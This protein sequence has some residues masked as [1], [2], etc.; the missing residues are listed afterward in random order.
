MAALMTSQPITFLF[1]EV[2]SCFMLKNN[3]IANFIGRIIPGILSIILVPVL[4]RHLGVEAYGLVGLFVSLQAMISFLDMGLSTTTNREVAIGLNTADKSQRT[5]N[6]VL[7]FEALYIAISLFIALGIY[8]ISNW[9]AS[10]WIKT[11]EL[12][13][14]TVRFAVIVFGV[15]LAIRWPLALYNGILQGSENQVLYNILSVVLAVMR[16]GG[17]IVIVVFVSSTILAYLLWLLVF[18]IV[19]IAVF[20]VAAWRVMRG[21]MSQKPR[22]DFSLFRQVWKFSVS[23][24]LNS[25]LAAL[26]KQLDRFLISNLLLLK[27]VG[28]YTT[29]HI[30][31]TAVSMLAIPFASAA[32]PRF[33]ALL[34]MNELDLLAATY[35]RLA[36]SVSFLAAPVTSILFFFSY[37]IMLIWTRSQDVASNAAPTLSIL[38]LAAM[39]NLMMHIPY[40]LQLAAGVTW[41]A[42]WNN[43]FS[44][45]I[46]LPFMYYSISRLGI[47]G[48]GMAWAIFNVCYYLIVPQVMHR[49]ILKGEKRVWIF[50]DTLPF[51]LLG[52]LIYG[53][54]YR[55][56]P[57]LE[58]P[59][60]LFSAILVGTILYVLVCLFLYPM[61]RRSARGLFLKIT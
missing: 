45:A 32:F 11:V 51:L 61:L 18:A 39:F 15:T 20:R 46:L 35:H 12:S 53:S 6:L 58:T 5:R 2:V 55:L 43:A 21:V 48:A 40:M 24:S 60:I 10:D 36:Q 28:Y 47:A 49:Y 9:L 57:M 54:I 17:S 19:E 34:A 31:Y 16:F 26:L 59:F 27:Y 14:N 7:T 29:A 13:V 38:A 4:L 22:F 42:L 50:Q 23:I 44:L 33:T 37:D 8:F 3:I 25:L 56:S 41:I 1:V 30:I 52:V